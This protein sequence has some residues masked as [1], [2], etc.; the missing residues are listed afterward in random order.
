MKRIA[1]AIC[2]VLAGCAQPLLI[3]V[4]R[5]L[6]QVSVHP[7]T[8]AQVHAHCVSLGAD[9]A[10]GTIAG[11]APFVNGTLYMYI[12]PP[13][14]LQDGRAFQIIGHELWYGVSGRFHP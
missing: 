9:A 13:T 1:L 2:F 6:F 4:E 5:T 14:D 12:T 10:G 8:P 7:M 3:D 11:C